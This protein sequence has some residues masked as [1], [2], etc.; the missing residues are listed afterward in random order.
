[1]QQFG[2]LRQT[3]QFGGGTEQQ[4]EQRSA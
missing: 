2:M 4:H 3:T 1:M